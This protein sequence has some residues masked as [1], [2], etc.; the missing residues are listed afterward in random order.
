MVQ[1]EHSEGLPPRAKCGE[2]GGAVP[3]GASDSEHPQRMPP[4][5]HHDPG[6]A[7]SGVGVATGG[8]DRFRP[9]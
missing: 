3:S 8:P 2:G 6:T 7:P 5:S 1:A 4:R 9:T